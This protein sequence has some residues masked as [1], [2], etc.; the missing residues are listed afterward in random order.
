[1]SKGVFR[2]GAA[3]RDAQ[4]NGCKRRRTEELFERIDA[5]MTTTTRV[6]YRAKLSSAPIYQSRSLD[7]SKLDKG[8]AKASLE[9]Q[10]R[11]RV[12]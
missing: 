6:M 1:M 8:E 7:G 11:V 3:K 4:R 9:G 5:A 12:V 2:Y 10:A